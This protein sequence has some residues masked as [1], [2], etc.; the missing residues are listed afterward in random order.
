M[1]ESL[2]GALFSTDFLAPNSTAKLITP[3]DPAHFLS[4][5]EESATRRVAHP[6]NGEVRPVLTHRTRCGRPGQSSRVE[7]Y[8]LESSALCRI[9]SRSE[10]ELA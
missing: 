7:S 8:P 5:Y 10:A 3:D 2:I 6:S 4:D 1:V 9:T